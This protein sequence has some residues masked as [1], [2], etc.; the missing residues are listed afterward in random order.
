[1]NQL[2]S[3]SAASDERAAPQVKIYRD[4][5]PHSSKPPALKLR[6]RFAARSPSR[7]SV[8]QTNLATIAVWRYPKLPIA[9]LACDLRVLVGEGPSLIPLISRLK[10]QRVVLKHQF[11]ISTQVEISFLV[12]FVFLLMTKE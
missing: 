1:M 10:Q 11:F 2:Q 6:V 8:G 7:F 5:K 9:K 4:L 3:Q 12:Q